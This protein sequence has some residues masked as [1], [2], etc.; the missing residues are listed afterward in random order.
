[1][2]TKQILTEPADPEA[3]ALDLI[4]TAAEEATGSTA[5]REVLQDYVGLLDTQGVLASL[6]WTDARQVA[7]AI[8]YDV[9]TADDGTGALRLRA[10]SVLAGRDQMPWTDR[11]ASA[12][13]LTVA[14]GRSPASRRRRLPVTLSLAAPALVVAPVGQRSVGRDG[15]RMDTGMVA[16][17]ARWHV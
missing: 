11:A 15:D 8:S 3:A 17:A 9:V 13:A 16:V 7:A 12:R 4:V 1:M 6:T 14:A 2:T 5:F 10:A